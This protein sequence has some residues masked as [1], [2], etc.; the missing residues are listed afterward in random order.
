MEF[1]RV[2]RNIVRW[3]KFIMNRKRSMKLMN[4]DMKE[5]SK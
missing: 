2:R 1:H 4:G 3:K 5:E